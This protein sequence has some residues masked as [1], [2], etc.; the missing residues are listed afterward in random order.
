M[1]KDWVEGLDFKNLSLNETLIPWCDW[2]MSPSIGRDKVTTIF[3]GATNQLRG[4]KF[5]HSLARNGYPTT[6][7]T[8]E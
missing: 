4:R 2:P 8:R 1:L 5:F 3:G 7:N 6:N